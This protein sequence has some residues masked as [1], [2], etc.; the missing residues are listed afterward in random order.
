[1][2]NVLYNGLFNQKVCCSDLSYSNPVC[3]L[4]GSKLRLNFFKNSVECCC[5]LNNTGV[6]DEHLFGLVSTRTRCNQ[7]PKFCCTDVHLRRHSRFRLRW[8]HESEWAHNNSFFLFPVEAD[9]SSSCVDLKDCPVTLDPVCGSD[10][11]TY[12]NICFLQSKERIKI[13]SKKATGESSWHL[14]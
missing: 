12:I 14:C 2:I 5:K 3:I 1:M 13:W 9:K 8:R 4:K 11:I 10:D 6:C 7:L